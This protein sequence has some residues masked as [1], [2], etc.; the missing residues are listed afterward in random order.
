MVTKHHESTE[1]KGQEVS[2]L[3]KDKQPCRQKV[4][5]RKKKQEDLVKWKKK[6]QGGNE[7]QI[8]EILL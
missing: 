7:V 2:P 8:A 1:S 5:K 3:K 4:E 6:C